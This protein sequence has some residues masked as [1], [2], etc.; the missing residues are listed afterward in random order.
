MSPAKDG[1]VIPSGSPDVGFRQH[2]CPDHRAVGT[3]GRS[4]QAGAT[5]RLRTER[6]TLPPFYTRG[7]DRISIDAIR[8]GNLFA[9]GFKK[10]DQIWTSLFRNGIRRALGVE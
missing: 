10:G 9:D 8:L 1:V 4:R 6:S 3:R 5:R 2:R 7:V